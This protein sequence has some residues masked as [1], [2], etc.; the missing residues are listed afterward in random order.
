MDL[1][2]TVR[3]TFEQRFSLREDIADRNVS[4]QWDLCAPSAT[5]TK[6]VPVTGPGPSTRRRRRC[7]TNKNR[8]DEEFELGETPPPAGLTGPGER[9]TWIC[10]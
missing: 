5:A 4:A 2:T 6:A 7:T 3:D 8:A 9:T 10:S 1:F